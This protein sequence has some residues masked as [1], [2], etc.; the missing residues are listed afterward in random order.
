MS[1]IFNEITL[2]KLFVP[3]FCILSSRLIQYD[4]EIFKNTIQVW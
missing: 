4:S 3:I 1:V 2:I